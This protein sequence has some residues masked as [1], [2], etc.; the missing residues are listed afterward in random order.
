METTL[1]VSMDKDLASRAEKLFSDI[2]MSITTAFTVFV[3]QSLREGGIPFDINVNLSADSHR[4]YVLSEL[5]K[6]KKEAASPDA[7]WYSEEEVWRIL[8][9]PI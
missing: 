4:Q 2:G 8:D 6:A 7:V 1:S 3:K 5:E 9:E